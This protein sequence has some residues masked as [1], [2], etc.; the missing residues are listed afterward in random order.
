VRVRFDESPAER[1]NA[2]G[3]A[4]NSTNSVFLRNEA[5]FLQRMRAA[6]VVRIQAPVYQEGEPAFEFR[7]EGFDEERYRS[8]E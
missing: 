5:R 8:V 2:V 7:V 4:D 3:P 6:K 1:W